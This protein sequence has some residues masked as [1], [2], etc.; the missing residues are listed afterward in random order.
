VPKERVS[1]AYRSTVELSFVFIINTTHWQEQL[2][3]SLITTTKRL[4]KFVTILT[5]TL[6]RIVLNTIL[7][8]GCA[9]NPL[10]ASGK[11]T[12]FFNNQ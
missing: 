4:I 10:R 9:S 7:K 1:N 3:Q 5:S 6:K 11:R 2:G 8:Y 12:A